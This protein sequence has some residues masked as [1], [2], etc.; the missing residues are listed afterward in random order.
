MAELSTRVLGERVI[1]AGWGR[2]LVARLELPDGTAID[3]EVEDHGIAVGVLPYDP[4]R[5][6]ALLVRQMRTPALYAAGLDSLLEAPAGRLDTDDPRVCAAREAHE[7][8]GLRLARLDFVVTAWTMPA[9]STERIHLFLAPFAAGDE[10]GRGGGL[11]EE[12]EDI[13]VERVRLSDIA[14]MMDQGELVDLK[15]LALALALRQRRPELFADHA[16]DTSGTP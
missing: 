16:D 8:V 14:R 11:P 13:T 6:I 1:H 3:R 15:T 7:E 5:R 2:F 4:D 10:V 12:G 9:V